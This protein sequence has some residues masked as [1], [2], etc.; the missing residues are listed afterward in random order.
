MAINPFAYIDPWEI[1][2]SIDE[3]LRSDAMFDASMRKLDLDM[4]R[5]QAQEERAA[6][7]AATAEEIARLNIEEA[8]GKQQRRNEAFDVLA[9]GDD[10]AALQ[11]I[12]ADTNKPAFQRS[13]AAQRIKALQPM[14]DAAEINTLASEGD[15]LTLA[16]VANDPEERPERRLAAQRAYGAL[17]V[18]NLRAALATNDPEQI[19]ANAG[20]LPGNPF[21]VIVDSTGRSSFAKPVTREQVLATL[22]GYEDQLIAA[23]QAQKLIARQQQ[24][25]IAAQPMQIQPEEAVVPETLSSE[26][27]QAALLKQYD[28][29]SQQLAFYRDKMAKELD[30]ATKAGEPDETIAAIR[31][32][33]NMVIQRANKSLLRIANAIAQLDDSMQNAGKYRP[34][35]VNELAR[36]FPQPTRS[37]ALPPPTSAQQLSSGAEALPPPTSAEQLSSGV[38]EFAMSPFGQHTGGERGEQ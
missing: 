23:E 31:S 3:R 28:Q 25:A 24:A 20:R 27:Q 10:Y 1:S 7:A 4:Q 17:V 35:E 26:Q 37:Q 32:R 11:A 15:W 29:L 19:A 2:R 13:L 12:A 5:A 16:N 36:R 30:D 21:G 9:A 18:R 33:Y 22:K 34:R 38:G 8:Q 6:R 14:R